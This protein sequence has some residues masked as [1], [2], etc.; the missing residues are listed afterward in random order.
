MS[1]TAAQC[2]GWV[3]PN[4]KTG[5]HLCSQDFVLCLK[6]KRGIQ[7]YNKDRGYKGCE[8]DMDTLGELAMKFNC[9]SGQYT[10]W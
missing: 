10:I 4:P 5:M 9:G 7:I 1:P 2:W 8:K 3:A 6:Y